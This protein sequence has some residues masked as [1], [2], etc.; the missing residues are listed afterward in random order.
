M[1]TFNMQ[2]MQNI[3]QFLRYVIEPNGLAIGLR[4][5]FDY[6]FA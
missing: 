1:K 2:T 5:H 6:D 4:F 3:E